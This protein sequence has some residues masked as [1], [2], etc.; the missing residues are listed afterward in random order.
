M[1]QLASTLQKGQSHERQGK[2]EGLAQVGRNKGDMTSEG[3]V[4]S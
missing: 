1:K 2:T 4:G 3:H